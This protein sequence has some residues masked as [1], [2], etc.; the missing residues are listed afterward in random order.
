MHA[1][2]TA[3]T[4]RLARRHDLPCVRC[5]L[6][7]VVQAERQYTGLLELQYLAKACLPDGAAFVVWTAH[8]REDDL[9]HAY[10][11]PSAE[12]SASTG[13]P[14]AMQRS[15]QCW[16]PWGTSGQTGVRGKGVPCLRLAVAGGQENRHR[17]RPPLAPNLPLACRQPDDLPVADG[18]CHGGRMVDG[19]VR[20]VFEPLFMASHELR[21]LFGD[22]PSL[23]QLSQRECCGGDDSSVQPK[24][25][26]AT[27]LNLATPQCSVACPAASRT[28]A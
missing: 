22:A 23:S 7:V 11:L 21:S 9:Y 6:P 19:C 13:A 17:P 25:A 26:E 12:L 4:T 28:C 16:L 18:G 5:C 20:P 2:G 8:R 27:R 10:L 15:L 3:A 24:H 1:E 14:P